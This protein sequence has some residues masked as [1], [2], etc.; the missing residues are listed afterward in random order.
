M[1]EYIL[2]VFVFIAFSFLL[3]VSGKRRLAVIGVVVETNEKLQW[4]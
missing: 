2:L 1:L 4:K 3:G